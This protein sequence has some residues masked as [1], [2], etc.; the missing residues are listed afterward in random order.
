MWDT[1]PSAYL[2]GREFARLFS[3]FHKI[4][5]GTY[6]HL[7]HKK[8]HLLSHRVICRKR[9]LQKG[10][11]MWKG[12]RM[13]WMVRLKSYIMLNYCFHCRKN[14]NDWNMRQRETLWSSLCCQQTHLFV[15]S[16]LNLQLCGHP[17]LIL[18]IECFQERHRVTV[19]E[20]SLFSIILEKDWTKY[21]LCML[22]FK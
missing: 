5:A 9:G 22:Y 1:H 20:K 3:P 21:S 4:Y 17:N 8:V 12:R 19:L 14:E 6:K 11:I 16:K 15:Q 13:T 18:R 2:L 10:G 7:M